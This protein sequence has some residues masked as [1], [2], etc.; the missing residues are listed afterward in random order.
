M[1]LLPPTVVPRFEID[2]DQPEAVWRMMGA[3]KTGQGRKTE[4]VGITYP[5][6]EKLEGR[7]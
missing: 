5:E 4:G 3:W 6:G 2:V 1:E 7:I